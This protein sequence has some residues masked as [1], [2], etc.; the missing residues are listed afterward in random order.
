MA[1][2]AYTPEQIIRKLHETEVFIGEGI[3]NLGQYMD[4]LKY[5][6]ETLDLKAE[7]DVVFED[8]TKIVDMVVLR[9]KYVGD[10]LVIP[11]TGRAGVNND[12]NLPY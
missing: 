8:D 12:K 1:R 9:G 6:H 3:T 7:M 10:F 5:V 2:K 4:A 11:P